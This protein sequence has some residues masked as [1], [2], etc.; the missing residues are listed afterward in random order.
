MTI[1]W[2]TCCSIDNIQVDEYKQDIS[3]PSIEHIEPLLGVDV[4]FQT[5][6]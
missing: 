6:H 4:I 3:G 5:I 2:Q 1:R